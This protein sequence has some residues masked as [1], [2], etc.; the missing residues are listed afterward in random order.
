MHTCYNW[1]LQRTVCC[2]VEVLIMIH[3][4]VSL[5]A[6]NDSTIKP[7]HKMD[8][9]RTTGRLGQGSLFVWCWDPSHVMCLQVVSCKGLSLSHNIPVSCVRV[10]SECMILGMG[11]CKQSSSNTWPILG[12]FYH[13]RLS[14]SLTQHLIYGCSHVDLI[15]GVVLI[16]TTIH[17]HHSLAPSAWEITSICCCCWP[18]KSSNLVQYPHNTC[19]CQPCSPLCND[20]TYVMHNLPLLECC[21]SNLRQI[22]T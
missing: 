20:I 5:D 9:L 1:K 7:H 21:P 6:H 16:Q 3:W 17:S 19:S 14:C 13:H 11:G 15:L 12:K 10:L 22:P 8:V 2:L 18:M 4:A